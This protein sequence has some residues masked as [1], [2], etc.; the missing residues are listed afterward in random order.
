MKHLKLFEQ[1]IL[2]GIFLTYNQV[3]PSDFKK[4]SDS[5]VELHPDNQITY[6][7][8][9]DMTW[10]TR[11]GDKEAHWK[12]D[13]DTYQLNHSEKDRDVLGLINSKKSVSKDHPWSK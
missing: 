11:K 8:K 10:G 4:F 7:K 5:Y 9:S 13:H 12:Y 3:I 2:E 1:F 6:D